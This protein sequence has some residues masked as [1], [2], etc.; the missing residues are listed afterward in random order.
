MRFV[1]IISILGLSALALTTCSND[2]VQL[3]TYKTEYVFVLVMDG[4]RYSETWGDPSHTNIPRMDT[5]MS[6]LGIINTAFY[7]NGE[8]NTTAGHTALSTGHYQS[9]NNSGGEYPIYPSI[10]QFYRKLTGCNSNSAWIVTSK[11]KLEIL[12]NT[13]DISWKDKFLPSTNCGISGLGSGYRHDSI[14][15]PI[16]MN[17]LT[18]HHPKLLYVNFREPD[19]SGHAGDWSAYL[20]GIKSVDEYIY[21]VWSFIQTDP[22]YKNKTTLFVTNDHGRHLDGIANGFVSHGDGCDGCRHLNFY[23][24]GPDFKSGIEINEPRELIDI[25]AT[26]SELLGLPKS[27]SKGNVMTELF[28]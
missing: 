28:D 24:F 19:F 21:Q 4:P 12:S 25:H 11:D 16:L 6:N 18:T 13:K 10:F 14:T 7:N 15:F 9:I 5:I 3:S 27:A 20:N 8:T 22:I 26:A 2:K 23:A 17:V 1:L